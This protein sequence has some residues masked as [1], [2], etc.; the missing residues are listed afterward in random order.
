MLS[1]LTKRESP[2][3]DENIRTIRHDLM[4]AV[5]T[6]IDAAGNEFDPSLQR[7]LLRAASFGKS[8]LESYSADRFVDMCR[9]IRILNAVRDKQIGIPLTYKQYVL[10]KR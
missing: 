1:R 5:S 3:A 6:C 8:F 7:A 9:S 2:K 4:D 10:L